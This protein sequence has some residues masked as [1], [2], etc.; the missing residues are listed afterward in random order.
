MTPLGWLGRKTSTQTNNAT[1][2]CRAQS[3]Y[4]TTLLLDRPSL[5]SSWPVLCTF[6]CQK[7]TTEPLESVEGREWTQKIFHDQISTKKCCRHG[8]GRTLNLLI[9]SRTCI[10]L[11][12]CGWCPCEPNWETVENL[13]K[14]LSVSILWINTVYNTRFIS[15]QFIINWS[16]FHTF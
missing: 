16:I 9:T 11:S 6:V 10:Q 7:L 5:L 12:H 3:V 1:G 14:C 13:I 8:G 4:L 2:S 15:P